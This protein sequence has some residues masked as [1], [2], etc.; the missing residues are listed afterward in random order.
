MNP[1]ETIMPPA[2]NTSASLIA[3]NFPGSPTSFTTW[4]SRRTSR[5]ASVFDAGSTT[6]PFLISNI[7]EILIFAELSFARRGPSNDDRVLESFV[8]RDARRPQFS[9]RRAGEES[10]LERLI[11]SGSVYARDIA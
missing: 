11:S 10:Q 8:L 7:L 9:P 1:G 3:A 5:G 4:P 6:R 2:S